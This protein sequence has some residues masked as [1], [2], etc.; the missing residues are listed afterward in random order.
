MA[1]KKALSPPRSVARDISSWAR[2]QVGDP[3]LRA[4]HLVRHPC[5]DPAA[6]PTGTTPCFSTVI[7]VSCACSVASRSW[8][9]M[10][11]LELPAQAHMQALC[12]SQTLLKALGIFGGAIF[13]MRNYG[14]L[15]AA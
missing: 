4:A 10:P 8:L 7:G 2:Q 5:P 6:A 15:F 11:R 13:V 12:A 9:P 1:P 3:E 14:E